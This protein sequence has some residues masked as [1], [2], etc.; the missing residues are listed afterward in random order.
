MAKTL[1]IIKKDLQGKTITRYKNIKNA[2]EINGINYK[3]LYEAI[4]GYRLNTGNFCSNILKG[5]IWE[6]DGKIKKSRKEIEKECKYYILNPNTEE[7]TRCGKLFMST[8]NGHRYCDSCRAAINEKFKN[9]NGKIKGKFIPTNAKEIS[10]NG[11]H[12]TD[13]RYL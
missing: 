6:M 2:A 9:T 4:N 1:P 7:Y 8:S 5:F 10:L 12:F 13:L 11:N 3:S